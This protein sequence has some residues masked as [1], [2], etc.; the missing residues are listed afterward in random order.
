MAHVADSMPVGHGAR[1]AVRN[2]ITMIFGSMTP[3][4]LEND[5]FN[6]DLI[7]QILSYYIYFTDL[8]LLSLIKV[9]YSDLLKNDDEKSSLGILHQHRR[10]LPNVR[11]PPRGT[12]RRRPFDRNE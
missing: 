10:G 3:R 5:L 4:D 9:K 1:S 2:T 8:K 6:A 12:Q 11:Q 7:V